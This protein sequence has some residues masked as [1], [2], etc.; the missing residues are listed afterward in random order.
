MTS[1]M[2][3]HWDWTFWIPRGFSLAAYMQSPPMIETIN[4][5]SIKTILNFKIIFI[6]T[7]AITRM[8]NILPKFGK[9]AIYDC[10][11]I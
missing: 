11:F 2:T 4:I 5:A 7:I 1:A 9:Y 10:H 6:I 3:L 8:T